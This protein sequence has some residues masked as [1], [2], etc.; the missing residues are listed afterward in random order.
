M[1]LRIASND[2]LLKKLKY[3]RH[4][5]TYL[6]PLIPLI[7]WHSKAMD[8]GRIKVMATKF[9]EKF[10]TCMLKKHR[11]FFRCCLTHLDSTPIFKKSFRYLW[12]MYWSRTMLIGILLLCKNGNFTKLD[13][14]ENLFFTLIK[15]SL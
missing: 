14:G 6:W 7:M 1:T 9:S 15:I 11:K 4:T 10:V 8:K 12:A 2:L 13:L 3:S 5:N